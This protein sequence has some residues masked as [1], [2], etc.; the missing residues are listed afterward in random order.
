MNIVKYKVYHVS[1]IKIIIFYV[2]FILYHRFYI[3]YY[4][5]CTVSSIKN[6]QPDDGRNEERPKLVVD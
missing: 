6:L 5:Y 2:F 3:S 4:I 1:L